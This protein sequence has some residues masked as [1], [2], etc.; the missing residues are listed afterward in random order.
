MG[1]CGIVSFIFLL[2]FFVFTCLDFV[3]VCSY[4]FRRFGG[5][6]VKGGVFFFNRG[7]VIGFKRF[8]YFCVFGDGSEGKRRK[9][10]CIY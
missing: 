10:V 7:W 8:L 1:W 5:Y 9:V 3:G 4:F 2:I 6:F